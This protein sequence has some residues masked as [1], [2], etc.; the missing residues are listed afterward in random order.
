MNS[1]GNFTAAK[2]AWVKENQ[3]ELYAQIDKIMLPGE[4]LSLCGG[5]GLSEMGLFCPSG[6]RTCLSGACPGQA[7][8]QP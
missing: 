6:R 4:W 3:P 1:P 8:A 7:G 2:L 5:G